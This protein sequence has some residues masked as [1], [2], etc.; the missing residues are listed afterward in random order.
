[1]AGTD[2]AFQAA[3]SAVERAKEALVEAVPSPRGRTRRSLAE[4]LAAFEG[5]LAQAARSLERWDDTRA[6]ALRAAV[7]DALR[8]AERLRLDAPSLNYEGL[9]T[10][11]GDLMEPLEAFAEGQPGSRRWPS[12]SSGTS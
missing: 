7:D 11:L 1:V 2:P 10:V 3:L 6:P 8:R 12:S 9:V 4:A 5:S